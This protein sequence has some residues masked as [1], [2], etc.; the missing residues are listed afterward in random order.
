M[1]LASRVNSTGTQRS[2]DTKEEFM[3]P[4]SYRRAAWIVL[5]L[6][7]PLWAQSLKTPAEESNWSRYTQYEDVA[8]FLQA[9]DQASKEAVVQ[10]AGKT[11]DAKELPAANLYLCIITEEGVDNPRAL[12]RRKPT[13]MITASQHGNEQSAKEG[14]LM[15]LRDLALGK[16]KPLLK[17]VNFLIMPQANPHGNFVDRRQNEQNLDLNRDHVKLES[18]ETQ[19]VHK[20]F[21]AW[22]PEVSLDLHEKGDDY[23][24]ISTG[25]VSNI[26]IN[27][28][29]ERY[30]REKVFP[31]LAKKVAADGFT[32]HEYLVSEALGSNEAAGVPDR[33]TAAG[34][35]RETLLRP[36][37]TDLNDGRN[38]PGIYDTL[39]FIQECSSQHNV[40]TLQERTRWQYSGI[41]A[42]IE[43]VAM[44]SKPVLALIHRSRADL[45]ARA[46][47]TAP[48]NVVHL[49]MQYVRDPKQPELTLKAFARQQG[50]RQNAA[51][52]PPEVETQVIKN[53]FPKVESRVAVSR[54]LGY[55]VPAD[56]KDVVKTLLDHGIAL[57]VFSKDTIVDG[58]TY[59][60]T[61]IVP[62][63]EDY[64]APAKIEVENRPGKV[65][66]RAG[67]FF[68]SVAQPAANLIPCLLE[69]QSEYGLIRYQA[70]KLVPQK[71]AT[72]PFVRVVKRKPSVA[73]YGGDVAKK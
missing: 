44:E 49:R 6:A 19:A 28:A 47:R 62:S 35:R 13:F 20:V 38:S 63:Q 1:N 5:L 56:R 60:I 12:N 70:Y 25:C 26:N 27:P 68:V 31:A 4:R 51:A 30:S 17:Q 65:T 14:A 46:A 22:M 29:I 24:R 21:R 40:P 59:T 50:A 41:R 64:V 57:G 66:A 43:F 71:G 34:Q 58:E 39:S 10:L 23:N 15:I 3:T 61:E 9:I 67:D 42:L 72:F 16:L 37:T 48:G 53:W 54:P 52:Q 73:P 33:S 32:W 2:F 36:S 18:P 45:L 11:L 8:R 55:I 7:A 69:P